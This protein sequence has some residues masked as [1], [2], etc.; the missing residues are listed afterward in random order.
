MRFD[1][2]RLRRS[3]EAARPQWSGA[4]HL[5][6]NNVHHG[7]SR[8]HASAHHFG[9]V[10]DQFDAPVRQATLTRLDPGGFI[11]PHRDAG[12]FFERWQVPIIPA[13]V[14]GDG[15]APSAGV[16]HRVSHWLPHSVWNTGVRARVVLLVD[17][18]REVRASG[19][20]EGPFPVPPEFQRLVD[21]A[22]G[23][24]VGVSE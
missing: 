13:G 24:G 8:A 17:L 9:W 18:D 16:A 11:L 6:Q 20:F 19:L 21:A 5:S 12:P 3:L 14:W 2:D 7:Y 10:F 23:S 1:P 4:S 22:G 15:F